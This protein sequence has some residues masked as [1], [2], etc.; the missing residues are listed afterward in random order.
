[1]GHTPERSTLKKLF[2]LSGNVCA[3]SSCSANI[4]NM[5]YGTLIGEVCHICGR[6]PGTARYDPSQT[7]SE[8]NAFENLIIMCPEHH[9]I[10]DDNEEKF[11]VE[12]LVTMKKEHESKAGAKFVVEDWVVDLLVES[13]S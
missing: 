6:Q 13:F 7:E 4:V 1:M 12:V 2:A 3:F 8:R 10:I 11:T 9:K 5:E